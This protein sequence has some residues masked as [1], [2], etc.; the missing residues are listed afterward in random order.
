MSVQF[1]LTP[2]QLRRICPHVPRSRGIPRVDD[3]RVLSGIIFVI[4]G[5]LRW[6]DAPPG[7]G[8]HKTLYNRFVR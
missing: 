8:P 4:K 1:L 7:Y 3:R 5:G 2:A 6:R